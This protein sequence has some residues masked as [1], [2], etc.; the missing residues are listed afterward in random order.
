M[1]KKTVVIAHSNPNERRA[2]IQKLA[3][4]P[5]FDIV[6]ETSD[7]VGTF[8]EVEDQLPQAVMISS[9]LA[10]RDEFEVMRALFRE[11]D[12]RWLVIA[13]APRSSPQSN[14]VRPKGSDLFTLPPSASEEELLTQLS[15]LTRSRVKQPPKTSQVQSSSM[16]GE[17]YQR[18]LLI[19]SSTGGIDALLTILKSFPANCP[20][21][22]I[23]Q[24]TGTGFGTSLVA[25]L[26]RQAPPDVVL[27]QHGMTLKRGRVILGAGE[28][29][30]LRL[31]SDRPVR[32]LLEKGDNISGHCPSVDALFQSAQP[33]ASRSVA[34][35][36][37]GMG[38]DGAEGLKHLRDNGAITYAQDKATSTVY[39][40]PRAAWELGA[41]DHQLPIDAIGPSL[42][43]SALAPV[44][45]KNRER[46]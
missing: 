12:V 11:L 38:R 27:A 1:P 25:L 29:R 17:G 15:S 9:D 33:L 22:V 3:G 36:L 23:V 2:L 7:L 30:H 19:G 18:M 31:S 45:R 32:I 8:A 34:V 13:N 43:K 10:D 37:T 41:V 4:T 39:G 5:D 6:G 21:T 14:R 44:A 28:R 35:I 46:V 16:A 40:M 24:H 42:L 26:N 20:P